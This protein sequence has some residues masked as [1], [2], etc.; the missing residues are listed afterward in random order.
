[1][2]RNTSES[3]KS[4]MFLAF[5]VIAHVVRPSNIPPVQTGAFS[6]SK[7]HADTSMHWYAADDAHIRYV[8]RIDFTLP[9][10]PV[11]SAPAVYIQVAFTGVSC[12]VKFQ[13]E[14]LHGRKNFYEA[15]IDNKIVK[16]IIPQPG[17]I[18]YNVVSGLPYGKH[19]LT[20][21]KRTESSVG[22]CTF[23]GFEFG[24]TIHK[25]DPLINTRKIQFFGNSISVGSGNEAKRN[26][27]P[28]QDWNESMEFSNAYA[29]F[30]AVLARKLKAQYHITGV[31]G[32]GMVRN[33]TG[34]D[35]RT[36]P[37]AH[38][39][40][41]LAE[42]NSPKWDL[43]KFI[44]D[45]IIIELGTNDFSP[46]DNLPSHPRPK[47][48]TATFVSAYIRFIDALQLVYPEAQIFCMYSPML[49]DGWPDQTY[50]SATDH[51][52]AINAI[53]KFY[54]TK[55][56]GKVHKLVVSKVAGEGCTTHPSA[57]EHAFI[58]SE[59]EKQVMTWMGW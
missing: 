7:P 35:L 24:G 4:I 39:L 1:M 2:Y 38:D 31:S 53:E 57:A 28:C 36:M 30:A 56:N 48:D 8:G 37:V 34:R 25:P 22:R 9:E 44:P 18:T 33:Y 20:F 51:T 46:G 32:I 27:L 21:V 19:H 15:I 11:F 23:L 5:M 14:F 3:S 45:A 42:A 49:K 12:N 43:K 16:K 40:L 58:A 50:R 29:S 59:M 41:H 6:P 55:G 17:I 47:M 54:M 52:I 10:K 26:S 13:D